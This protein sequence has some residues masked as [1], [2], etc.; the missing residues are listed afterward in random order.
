MKGVTEDVTEIILNLKQVR[1]KKHVEHD[2]ATEKISLSIKNRTEFTAGML[3]E[4]S[5]HFQVMNPE[6]VICT[7][8][9]SAKMDIELTI[10]RGRGYIPAEENKVKDAPFGYIAIDSIHT[11]IKN[12]KYGIENYRVEQRTDYELSLIHI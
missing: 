10:S 9:S 5:Q 12:V 8:D 3:G 6:L 11:P 4:V 7:M 1:F 2:V